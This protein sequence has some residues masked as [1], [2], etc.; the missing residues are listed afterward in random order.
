[1]TIKFIEILASWARPWKQF[2][3][4][5]GADQ[6]LIRIMGGTK[7][8]TVTFDWIPDVAQPFWECACVTQIKWRYHAQW[9]ELGVLTWDVQH[10]LEKMS[11]CW[12][13]TCSEYGSRL[14]PINTPWIF[15]LKELLVSHAPDLLL[16]NDLG[17]QTSHNLIHRNSHY[18]S[19]TTEMFPI[20]TLGKDKVYEHLSTVLKQ[21]IRNH[22]TMFQ[23]QNL[24]FW[25][26]KQNFHHF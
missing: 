1:M 13:V 7:S 3:Y 18:D 4:A 22:H 26:Q 19:K 15:Q 10:C 23:F 16:I 24:I 12:C 17:W 8:C 9:W 2:H 21:I 14:F 25:S 20:I 6:D 11:W 5:Y